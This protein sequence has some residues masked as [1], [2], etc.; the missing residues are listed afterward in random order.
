M[1]ETDLAFVSQALLASALYYGI[2]GGVIGY[3]V[4]AIVVSIVRFLLSLISK[5]A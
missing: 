5:R 1:S 2:A 4:C 3:V